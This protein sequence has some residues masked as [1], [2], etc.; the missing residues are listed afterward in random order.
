MSSVTLKETDAAYMVEI[1][2]DGVVVDGHSFPKGDPAELGELTDVTN[3]GLRAMAKAFST[4]FMAALLY[5]GGRTDF[6]LVDQ[7]S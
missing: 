6:E 2:V 3:D 7:L 1:E 4:G 5:A